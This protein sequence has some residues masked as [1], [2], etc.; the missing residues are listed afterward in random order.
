MSNYQVSEDYLLNHA[1]RNVWCTPEQD[2]QAI[3]Q[4]ARV[5]PE[6]GV[7]TYFNYQWRK[8][9]LPVI[10]SDARFHIYQIGQVHPAILGLLARANTWISAKEVMEQECVLMDVYTAKGVMI[11][12]SLCWY[13]VTGDKNLL[14][15]VRKPSERPSK[16]LDVDLEVEPVFVRLYSNAYFNSLRANYPGGS[17][18]VNSVKADSIT[19]INALQAEIQTLPSYGGTF[20]YVNGRRTSGIDLVTAKVGDYIEY[21]FDASIKREVVFKVRDLQEFQSTLDNLNKYLLHYPGTSNLIDYQDDVDVYLGEQYNTNRWRGVYVHK[22]DSRTLRMVTHRDY[23]IPVVRV[24]GTQA[25]NSFLVGV[26]INNLELRLTIRHSGYERPL[27]LENN[28]VFELYKLPEQRFAATLLGLDSTVSVWEAS[29]LEA[30]AYTELMRQPQG[31]ITR[32]MVQQ[33]YGYNAM[34]KLLGDTPQRVAVANGQK[35]V[36]ILEGLRGCCT[37]YEYNAAGKLLYF[38]QHATDNTYVCQAADTAFAEVIYGLGGTI[39]DVY[40]NTA[41]G[42]INPL[43]NYRFY[44]APSVAGIRTGDWADRTGDPYYLVQDGTYTWVDNE[45]QVTRVLSN[46]RHLAYTFEMAPIAGV[47]EFDIT[48]FKDNIYQKLDIPLGEFDLFF[49]GYSLIEGL[50]FVMKDAR[51]VVTTKKYYDST[52]EKQSLTVRYTGFCNKD[53]TRTAIPDV[54]FV[55]H[56]NL[57]ANNRFNT[58]DDKVLRI[59]CAGTVRLRTDLDFAEDGIGV[60]LAN[61]LNGAPYAIRDIV[62]PMNN[63]LIAGEPG[64]DKTYA[65]RAQAMEVDQEISDYMTKWLPETKVEQPNTITG[66]YPIYSPFFSRIVADLKSGVLWDDKF[67]E[68]FG[69]DWLRG[70]LASYER[71]LEFDPIGTGMV[72]DSRYVVV[73]PHPYTEYV[74]LTMYQY[75]VLD[76]IAKLYAPD[77]DLSST[78]N[79]LQF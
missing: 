16:L 43:H 36:E 50:D 54:G 26:P 73:H 7:W 14:V 11:P 8:I 4:P 55:Y 15:A 13:I 29:A 61:A 71:L 6:N 31:S 69:D 60:S 2:K 10:G 59:V 35:T 27:V 45:T 22:N 48:I 68:H 21:V 76:R 74:S 32:Q 37:V 46:K 39:L 17:I 57:S 47:F 62:V 19:D 33:A 41:T 75:R 3:I 77:L 28:R 40:D 63:Y 38:T 5:T 58:R 12:R 44:T 53:M 72:I 24:N 79:V 49:N 65:Y 18:R 56:G 30:S 67:Y 78:I 1:Y 66:R 9:Q 34:S 25:A 42:S 64:A 52:R 20:F 70:R 51:V 23:S